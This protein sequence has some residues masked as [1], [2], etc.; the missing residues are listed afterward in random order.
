[1]SANSLPVGTD[2]VLGMRR[3]AGRLPHTAGA[4]AGL[5][6]LTYLLISM[7]AIIEYQPRY[8]KINAFNPI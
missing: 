8:R 7:S 4:L 1:M 3:A 5:G 6:Q 2:A